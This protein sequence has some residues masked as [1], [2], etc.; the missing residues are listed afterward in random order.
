[1][2]GVTL[3]DGRRGTNIVVVIRRQKCSWDGHVGK[4]EEQQNGDRGMGNEDGREL[5]EVTTLRISIRNEGFYAL[6]NSFGW[7]VVYGFA[8]PNCS[9]VTCASDL[10]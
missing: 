5:D 1:M 4:V 6:E 2:T 7:Q 9:V 3:R 8:K 10:R